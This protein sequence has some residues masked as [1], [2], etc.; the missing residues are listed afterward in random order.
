MYDVLSVIPLS[1]PI[2]Y[3][4]FSTQ[5]IDF[6]IFFSKN[7]YLCSQKVDEHE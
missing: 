1:F 3:L 5:T 6:V 4:S 2:Q 7:H